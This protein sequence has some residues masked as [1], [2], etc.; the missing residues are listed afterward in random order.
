MRQ[1]DG[2]ALVLMLGVIGAVVVGALVLVGLGQALGG[3]SRHQ[4][5]ADLA[6][7]SAAHRMS[8]D[9]FRLFEPV[10]LP[11]GLPNPSHLP[12]DEYLARARSVA[13]R[14]GTRN[15]VRIASADVGFPGGGFAPTRIRVSARGA[16]EVRVGDRPARRRVEVEATATAELAVLAGEPGMP[17]M[18]SGGGYSG[19]LAYRGGKPMRPDVAIAF[20]RMAAAARVDGIALIVVSGF[21]S[22]AEQAALFAAHPDPKWVAP[23]GKS[24]HRLGTE[25][26][27]GPD[28]A[29]GW[30]A[31]NAPR[32]GFVKRYAWEPWHYGYTRS[33]G[34]A[35]VGYG[36]AIRDGRSAIPA[37]VPR[38]LVDE[39]SR[40]SQ[41]WNVGAAVL[42]AQLYAES[43][44]NPFATSPAGAQG[45]AQFMPGTAASYGLSNP[46]D[47][48]AAIDAQAHLM[49]DLLRQFASVPLAL[50]AYNAGPAPVQACGCIPPYP[51]TQA[52]VAKILGL[53]DGAGDLTGSAFEV[54][55]VE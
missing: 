12:T 34:S 43:N 49:H 38:E 36:T 45:I 52:Y 25:L 4:R 11:N 29:Y 23:P 5:A 24:L 10:A 2:Q 40:A 3:K 53:L 26:D 16:I 6:A 9:Y 32:F 28:A 1:E 8:D 55:L 47:P 42:A 15:G 41:R 22:D 46:F 31:A 17:T 7:V 44:F 13:V 18:A 19:P 27:L 30:L 50:A 35:S 39:I 37:F 54:R 33:A 21:R 48:A 20:D 14:V 51:E